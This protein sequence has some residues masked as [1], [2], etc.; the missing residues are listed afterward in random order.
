MS[1]ALTGFW[2]LPAWAAEIDARS[3]AQLILK[4]ILSHPAVTCA[5]PATTRV[6]H[7]RQNMAAATGRLP[8]AA[9]RARMIAYVEDL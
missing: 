3:W 4:F 2:L 8:D 9:M 7:V 6:E 1:Q 5:I